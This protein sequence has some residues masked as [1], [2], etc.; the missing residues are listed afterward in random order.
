MPPSS[1]SP[2]GEFAPPA[3][4]QAGL[5][6][7]AITICLD[8]VSHSM[9]F[10]VLPRLVE[11]LVGGQVASAARW[12][13]VL[14][15]A[16]SVAQFFAAPVIGMLS[17]RFGRRPVILIS[18]FGLSLDLA[19]MALAPTLAWLLIGRI[20]CGLTAG[21][22]GAAMAYVADITP[23]EDR[24]KSY[25]WLNAAAWTGV[26]LGPA[27]GGLMG[28]VDPRAPFWTAAAVALANGLY[29]LLVLPESLP[30]DR[31]APMRWA[32]ANPIGALGL[33]V[34]RPGLPVLSAALLLMWFA[35]FAMNSVFVLYTAYRYAWDPM[36]LGVFCSA[37]AAVNI[38]V[39]S[40]LSGRAAAWFG[41]R[42]TLLFGLVAQVIGFVACGLAPNGVLFWI[43]NIPMTLANIAG[44]ALQSLMTARVDADEQ[45]RLQGAMG[46]VSSLTGLFGPIAFTQIFALAIAGGRGPAWSGVT[47]LFGAALSLIAWLLVAI[48][49]RE[50]GPG[51]DP[52]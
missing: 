18:I 5:P 40:Q 50:A 6:F 23:Q 8:V 24:A 1:S 12:V 39:T 14:V 44:P 45:G 9:V 3:A 29:G 35:M 51:P 52:A 26:I 42:R 16:W 34:S 49:T 11:G 10:P 48:Y 4:R 43:A 20:L 19:I 27:V 41:E 47:I 36:A 15:A 17:D 32:K 25:G 2:P 28:A 46:G 33:L 22:Q 31:R 37:L 21:A 30:R 13:G 38:V 7:I